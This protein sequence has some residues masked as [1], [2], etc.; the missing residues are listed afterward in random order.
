MFRVMVV[1]G[2]LAISLAAFSQA[3][4]EYYVET[5]VQQ[6]HSD[7]ILTTDISADGRFLVTGSA[8][9]TV[10]L[11]DLRTGREIRTFTG[12]QGEVREVRIDV[13][14]GI[15]VSAAEKTG[16]AELRVWNIFSE[17]GEREVKA[18]KDLTVMGV[19]FGKLDFE[20]AF[21]VR[22]FDVLPNGTL[23]WAEDNL[24]VRMGK[25][26]K[27]SYDRILETN[28]QPTIVRYD[29]THT[30]LVSGGQSFGRKVGTNS[31]EIARW[32]TKDNSRLSSLVTRYESIRT[33]CFDRSGDL[34][35][36][37]SFIP[38]STQLI[39]ALAMNQD[40]ALELFSM[41]TGKSLFVHTW[42][43]IE[44]HTMALS[45]D[46]S[47]IV[48]TNRTGSGNAQLLIIDVNQGKVIQQADAG[49]PEIYS[50][51][52]SPDGRTLI[53]NGRQITF[54]RTNAWSA[55]KNIVNLDRIN[56]V[57]VE[58]RKILTVSQGP[59]K[60][61]VTT[62]DMETGHYEGLEGPTKGPSRFQS[63]RRLR[64]EQNKVVRVSLSG[65]ILET[66][67]DEVEGWDVISDVA[68]TND[69]EFVVC[70]NESSPKVYVK[71]L[72]GTGKGFFL[73]G[74]R[75]S[76]NCIA[77]AGSLLAT[78]GNDNRII[79]WNLAEGKKLGELLGHNGNVQALAFNPDGTMLASGASDDYVKLWDVKK[80]ASIETLRGHTSDV[81]TVAFNE[82]GT[83]LVSASGDPGYYGE[84]VLIGW[85]VK[86]KKELWRQHGNAGYTQQVLVRGTSVYSVGNDPVVRIYDLAKGK[87]R[88][89]YVPISTTDFVMSAADNYYMATKG[90]MSHI[91]FVKGV[92]VYSFDNFDLKYNRADLVLKKLES[93][94]TALIDAHR[95]IYLRRLHKQRLTEAAIK[96]ELQLPVV[97][98]ENMDS[99]GYIAE[100]KEVSLSLSFDGVKS[101]LHS[102]NVWINGVPLFGTTGQ[103]TPDRKSYKTRVKV[104][105]TDGRNKIE[106]GCTTD[107]GVKSPREQIELVWSEKEPQDLYLVTVCTSQ[108]RDPSMN[109][110]Y[111]VKDGKD[112]VGLF[113]QDKQ[114][115][116][117]YAI[118]LYNEQVTRENFRKIRSRLTKAKPNDEIILFMAGHG[119]LDAGFDFHFVTYDMD[120]AQP[121]ASGISFDDIE[122]LMDSLH[123]RHKVVLIDACH[124]GGVDKQEIEEKAEELARGMGK[125]TKVQRMDALKK[126]AF[127]MY[128]GVDNTFVELMETMYYGLGDGTGAYVISAAAGNGYAFE[129]EQWNNGVFTYS[130]ING[131]RNAQAD[132]D[133]N[134]AVSV[135]ELKEY[136][137]NSVVKLTDNQQRPTCRKENPDLDFDVWTTKK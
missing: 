103:Q 107:A 29:P 106:V 9:H 115:A 137:V 54:W 125:N 136:L 24:G 101:S 111:S 91:H 41:K 89:I 8:D 82:S 87:P 63:G 135:R 90:S 26:T 117:V 92:Q 19:L 42:K 75:R 2:L 108:Y 4:E 25:V 116:N 3:Q 10:K 34:L 131:L 68:M 28:W 44:S 114:F 110:T 71:P 48:L 57:A 126:N 80:M 133:S 118:T 55:V 22:S 64:C 38:D 30:T 61:L 5:V 120:L 27:S 39:G 72:T 113:Q 47:T 70:L 50:M 81:M 123:A 74:H 60:T 128:Y 58:G 78:G 83:T 46:G 67:V 96:A 65:E 121:A 56:E 35:A 45:P 37:L 62:F 76:V 112:M 93:A 6:N 12:H 23:V 85:D 36:V 31:N 69:G 43:G 105:L 13:E 17:S 104:V 51:A 97:R 11:W 77:N 14:N 33:V 84:S 86:R 7:R 16:G 99:L 94:N 59:A 130:L 1:G 49:E 79:L 40:Q 129:S 88:F 100:R 132:A 53:A 15:I 52:F 73:E 109:L 66:V 95:K 20:W 32:N 102:F 124:S 21:E 127:R 119:V 98:I 18:G 134:G 122:H